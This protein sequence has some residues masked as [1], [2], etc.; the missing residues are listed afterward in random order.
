MARETLRC[1]RIVS[2]EGEKMKDTKEEVIKEYLAHDP[3]NTR[4]FKSILKRWQRL[5][6]ESDPI[7]AYNALDKAA[8]SS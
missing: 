7:R 1:L 2:E 4:K 3:E 8:M 5:T 6:N